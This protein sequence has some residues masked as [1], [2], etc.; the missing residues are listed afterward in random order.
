MKVVLPVPAVSTIIVDVSHWKSSPAILRSC[1]IATK[2]LQTVKVLQIACSWSAGRWLALT[3]LNNMVHIWYISG[4]AH[5]GDGNQVAVVAQ[6][7][8]SPAA[9]Y[10]EKSKKFSSKTLSRKRVMLK[11]RTCVFKKCLSLLYLIRNQIKLLAQNVS[12][13]ITIL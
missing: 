13:I 4:I 12:Y 1:N 9:P 7:T 10:N 3:N 6:A 8:S 2:V 5:C 11:Y